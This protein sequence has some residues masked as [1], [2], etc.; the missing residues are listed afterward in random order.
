MHG[1]EFCANFAWG[2][3]ENEPVDWNKIPGEKVWGFEGEHSILSNHSPCTIKRN[4]REYP[5]VAFAH[6]ATRSRYDKVD[7]SL[8]RNLSGSS[9]HR[10]TKF[11]DYLEGDWGGDDTGAMKAMLREKFN[12]ELHP[13]NAKVLLETGDATLVAVDEPGATLKGLTWGVNQEGVGHNELGTM[14]ESV[15][16]ELKESLLQYRM[17]LLAMRAVGVARQPEPTESALQAA[18]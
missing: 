3:V 18:D 14:L 8:G 16:E 10:K 1:K 12:P 15:R 7:P 13:E 17:T 4:G 6:A 9:T 11:Y 2:Q 5:S